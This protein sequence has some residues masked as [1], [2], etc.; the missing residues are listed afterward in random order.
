MLLSHQ[1]FSSLNWLLVLYT[2]T[3]SLWRL[4][5]RLI[6]HST[7][8]NAS[9]E[10]FASFDDDDDA[11][12]QSPTVSSEVITLAGFITTPAVSPEATTTVIA[13]GGYTTC[14][15]GR[16]WWVHSDHYNRHLQYV[17]LLM[18]DL[19]LSELS[20]TLCCS[21]SRTRRTRDDK[22]SC[23]SN[24]SCFASIIVQL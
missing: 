12:W 21:R 1:V 24:L 5:Y 13:G 14:Y 8:F 19:Q 22:H 18:N 11:D 16:G 20:G 23:T 15:I 2:H 6:D 7:T 17:Y 4:L 9:I 10:L 3:R